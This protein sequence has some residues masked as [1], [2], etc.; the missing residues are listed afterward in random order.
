MYPM[1]A[2]PS[3]IAIQRGMTMRLSNRKEEIQRGAINAI[4][5]AAGCNTM[6]PAIDEGDDVILSYQAAGSEE[7][8]MLGLQLKATSARNRWNAQHTEITAHLSRQRYDKYR[9]TNVTFPKIIV[10]M[11]LPE[12]V[13]DWVDISPERMGVGKNYWVSIA[14]F[15]EKNRTGQIAVRASADNVFDDAALCGIMNG[16]MEK[17]V[18][19]S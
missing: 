11:D 16:L 6:V 14:G 9:S 3:G 18:Q 19:Q 2:L 17:E 13:D 7:M 1:T 10:I 15:P 12:S 8:K 5:A 4:A